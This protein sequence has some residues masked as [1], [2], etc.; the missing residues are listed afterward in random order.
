MQLVQNMFHTHAISFSTYISR[1]FIYKSLKMTPKNRI[2]EGE[3][4]IKGEGGSK[5]TQK[6]FE[7]TGLQ[8]IF[9]QNLNTLCLSKT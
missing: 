9:T 1:T 3:N 8:Y 5:M 2:I 6:I 4:Q 7:Q